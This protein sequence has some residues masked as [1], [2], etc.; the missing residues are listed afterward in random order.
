MNKL[1]FSLICGCLMCTATMTIQAQEGSASGES[2]FKEIA[3]N[4][5]DIELRKLAMSRLNDQSVFKEIALNDKNLELRKLAMSLLN[6]QSAFK[7]IALN[8]KNLELRKLAM[9]R[10]NDQSTFKEIALNDKEN[11]ELRKLAMLLLK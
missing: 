10:L 2:V 7:E 6:D 11:T 8:D 3:L 5:K 1:F 9:S 4:D